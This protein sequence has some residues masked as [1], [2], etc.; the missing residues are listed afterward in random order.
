[1]YIHCVYT[2]ATHE[3]DEDFQIRQFDRGALPKALGIE[4]G[5]EMRVREEQGKYV[6]EPVAKEPRKIDLTGISDRYLAEAGP[7][8]SNMSPRDWHLIELPK[9]G[10]SAYLLDTNC[11]VY[12]FAKSSGTRGRVSRRAPANRGYP[13]RFAPNLRSAMTGRRRDSRRSTGSWQMPLRAIRRG[14]GACYRASRSSAALDRLIAAHALSLGTRDH[15]STTSATSRI[16][17]G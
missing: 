12:L 13:R 3:N 5:T 7:R 14:R 10:R 16:V 2:G 1:M 9:I 8:D 15:H 6:L 4:A 17:P 11:C